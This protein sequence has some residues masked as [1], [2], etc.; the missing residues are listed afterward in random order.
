MK[1]ILNK[2][3]IIILAVIAIVFL[4]FSLFYK[5]KQTLPQLLLSSPTEGSTRASLTGPIQLKFD[6]EIDPTLLTITSSPIEEWNTQSSDNK[7]V[8]LLKSKQ[9]LHVE[10]KYILNIS[11]NKQPIA[12]LN[13][14]TIAQQG[15]PRYTQEVLNEMDRDYPIAVKL[16]YNTDLY[17]VV[18]SAPMI[19]EITI[20]NENI[21][22]E[23]AFSEIRAWV[24]SVGGDPDAHKYVIGDKPWTPTP[25]PTLHIESD[26]S[27]EMTP[28]A[29]PSGSP[30][31]WDTLEDDG[32]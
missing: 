2:K 27:R 17:R 13:F 4:I 19:L 5:P 29:K 7:F 9:Y 25:T 1:N 10:T 12:T 21:L 6:K 28:D 23:K 22:P 20:K 8:I 30:F 16:P 26:S 24:T 15:D 18:Y 14:K 11:Y 32:T 3:Y 31:N